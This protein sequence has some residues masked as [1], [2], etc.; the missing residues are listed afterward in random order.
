MKPRYWTR[1][2]LLDR[3]NGLKRIIAKSLSAR[4]LWHAAARGDSMNRLHQPTASTDCSR[5]RPAFLG[6]HSCRRRLYSSVS[7]SPDRT[8]L[9]ARSTV[10]Q[11]KLALRG[12]SMAIERGPTPSAGWRSARGLFTGGSIRRRH[13]ATA[14]GVLE[15]RS[16]LLAAPQ[17]SPQLTRRICRPFDSVAGLAWSV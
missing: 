8:S 15:V 17:C 5:P 10:N 9:S 6:Q 12:E 13:S 14:A 7:H 16:V 3:S 2:R 11:S 4:C 1:W